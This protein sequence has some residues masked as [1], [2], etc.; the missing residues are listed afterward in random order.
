V[1]KAKGRGTA[2]ADKHPADDLVNGP[3][4]NGIDDL[5][6]PEITNVNGIDATAS[7]VCTV[8][9]DQKKVV[10]IISQIHGK[11]HIDKTRQRDRVA[12]ATGKAA[13]LD[14]RTRPRA[15]GSKMIWPQATLRD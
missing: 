13:V 10:A 11:K 14:R 6:T 8:E 5:Y 1:I 2:W 12:L 9:N 7:M 4:G 3:S 15:S